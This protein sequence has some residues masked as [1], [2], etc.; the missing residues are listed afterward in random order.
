MKYVEG[1]LVTLPSQGRAMVVTDLH[2]NLEDFNKVTTLWG[3]CLNRKCHLILTGDF[4]HA[5]GRANDHSIDIIEEVQYYAAKY[6]TFH[7]LLGNHEWATITNILI[8]K[9]GVNQN[10]N[11]EQLLRETFPDAWKEKLEEYINFFQ[12]LPVAVRTENGVFISHSGPANVQNLDDIKNL[13]GNGYLDNQPLYD[14]LWRREANKKDVNQFLEKVDCRALVVGHTPVNGYK[15]KGNLL[16][17]SSSYGKG[18]KA[19]LELDLEKK[20]HN[21]RDLESMI[22]YFR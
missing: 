14:L 6:D 19:Y 15:L 22:K 9:G 3:K 18:K 21:G 10:L 17:V 1:D 7:P 13:T 5:M 4:I 12:T 20:I 2:G 8:Y 11:F 16:I